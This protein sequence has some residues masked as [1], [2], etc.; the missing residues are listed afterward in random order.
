MI[1][2]LP[3]YCIVGDRPVKA[4]ETDSGGMEVMALNWENGN[5]ERDMKYLDR[6]L[7]G[8]IE[9]SVVDKKDFIS[10]VDEIRSKV[11]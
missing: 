11:I 4:I 6:I 9:V 5:F 10:K 2:D 7:S 8:D 1:M 3:L